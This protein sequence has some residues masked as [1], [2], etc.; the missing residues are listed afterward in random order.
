[1]RI[2][3][4]GFFFTYIGKLT[5]PAKK[6]G[7]QDSSKKKFSP[8]FSR[9]IQK[10]KGVKTQFFKKMSSIVDKYLKEC[11]TRRIE[12]YFAFIHRIHEGVVE[13]HLDFLS[14]DHLRLV[15]Y[16]LGATEEGVK[17]NPSSPPILPHRSLVMLRLAKGVQ[18]GGHLHAPVSSQNK[19]SYKALVVQY[20]EP[21][22]KYSKAI[23]SRMASAAAAALRSN[24]TSLLSLQL[25]G[26]NF[27]ADDMKK[28]ADVLPFCVVLRSLSFS[29]SEMG[30]AA[31]MA[32]V[33]AL[34]QLKSI[35]KLDLSF[36]DISSARIVS[37]IIA[38][39]VEK[40]SKCNWA[41]SMREDD[42]P[43]ST[44]SFA[45]CDLDLSHNTLDDIGVAAF[46]KGQSCWECHLT[47][48]DLSFNLIERTET[49]R[50]VAAC[51]VRTGSSCQCIDI[52]GNPVAMED[53]LLQHPCALTSLGSALQ[54][55]QPEILLLHRGLLVRSHLPHQILTKSTT[56]NPIGSLSMELPVT[57]KRAQKGAS[58][59]SDSEKKKMLKKNSSPAIR[60]EEA[61]MEEKFLIVEEEEEVARVTRHVHQSVQTTPEMY[62]TTH[63]YY[64]SYPAVPQAQPSHMLLPVMLWP[65]PTSTSLSQPFL[66]QH[67]FAASV[68]NP[69]S[70]QPPLQQPTPHDLVKQSSGS[71][72]VEDDE[73]LKHMASEYFVSDISATDNVDDGF[74]EG[75]RNSQSEA[76]KNGRRVAP[77][78]GTA[79]DP[80]KQAL[81]NFDVPNVERRGSNDKGDDAVQLEE[82]LQTAASP[83]ADDTHEAELA[84]QPFASPSW[85]DTVTSMI[86]SQV[87]AKMT[88]LL[89]KMDLGEEQTMVALEQLRSD[90]N[91]HQVTIE[92]QTSRSSEY[93]SK[94]LLHVHSELE[95][96][97]RSIMDNRVVIIKDATVPDTDF[98]SSGLTRDVAT[99]I[100][101]GLQTVQQKL[102]SN[103]ATLNQRMGSN[104]LGSTT[105]ATRAP[106]NVVASSLAGASKAGGYPLSD[107]KEGKTIS[108]KEEVSARLSSLGW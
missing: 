24:F 45:L 59:T 16:C 107:A 79:H 93:E 78:V 68:L 83:E 33:T 47:K 63:P 53:P 17:E 97:T 98:I 29:H 41:Y 39:N 23:T 54:S 106:L 108:F 7:R 48:L 8:Q 26:I 18:K 3:S 14:V 15:C 61:R 46:T 20:G 5:L 28:I 71:L 90:L 12:P 21:P 102:T 69:S 44:S 10:K 42:S 105:Q 73:A 95:K 22:V 70:S 60:K 27:N 80:K 2:I 50:A 77:A 67:P 52:S 72:A 75:R 64:S 99:L 1:M 81:V 36:C 88:Q 103:S 38:S 4:T 51:M 66:Y 100:H 35:A 31:A 94:V 96:R 34:P 89:F 43:N 30:D 82:L 11:S 87:D 65:P 76:Q 104:Y 92:A 62:G 32:L 101:K 40:V 84:A 6:R 86:S 13:C 56:F 57:T 58:Y 91:R 85:E 25:V 55:Y 9:R 19:K 37:A 74:V 49:I